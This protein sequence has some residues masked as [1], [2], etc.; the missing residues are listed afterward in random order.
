[1]TIKFTRNTV[2]LASAGTG[3]TRALVEVF[4]SLIEEGHDPVRI[5]AVTF[6]EKAAAE[7]R[8]RIRRAIFNRIP[9]LDPSEQARWMRTVAVL[10]AA[11][12]QTIHGFCGSI[13]RE[14][15]VAKGIDPG[16]SILD[17][18]S[19]IELCRAAAFETIRED[20]VGGDEGVRRL[21]GDLGLDRLIEAIPAAIYW[22]HSLGVDDNWLEKRCGEQET[23]ARKIEDE[24]SVQM[25]QYGGSPEAIG[26][27]ADAIKSGTGARRHPLK[28]RKDPS[29]LLPRVGQ[30][31]GVADARAFS[32]LVERSR[33]RFDEQKRS[34]NV[35]DFDDLLLETR[36]LLRDSERVRAACLDRFDAILVDEFQDTDDVQSQIIS[37]LGE[38]PDHPGRLG[39][40]RLLVV[41][42]PKQSI[43]R[44][45]RARV[46]EFFRMTDRVVGAEGE[47]QHLSKNFRSAAPLIAFSNAVSRGMLD[48]AGKKGVTPG[49]VDLSYR[50]T[51]S[52][53]D[54][55]SA[56]ADVAFGGITFLAARD[57]AT[58]SEG[59]G[60]EAGAIARLLL[61]RKSSNLISCWREVGMLFRS[62]THMDVYVRALEERG[63]PV[64]VVQGTG[65]YDT[66]EV[67]D[68]IAALE[69][70]VRPH[71]RMARA[72]LRMSALIGD[73]FE[74]LLSDAD[75]DPLP[76]VFGPWIERRDRATAAEILSDVV[77][78]TDFDVVMMAQRNGR[79]RVANIGKLIEITRDLARQGT[80]SL[81]DVVRYL[82]NRVHDPSIRE[83]EVQILGH[84]DDVVQC[85]TVHQAKGL[86][87]DT[88][89]LPNLAGGV[90]SG[91][92]DRIFR[93]ERWG[94]LMAP[95][96]GVHRKALPHS[97]ILEAKAYESDQEYEEEKRLLYVAMTRARKSLVLG[98]G[99]SSR[100]G[101]WSGWI[102]P[103]VKTM[104]PGGIE[105]ARA[106][107]NVGADPASEI[108]IDIVAVVD[109]RPAGPGG[110]S[111]S[112]VADVIRAEVESGSEEELPV[113]TPAMPSS[114]E[115]TPSQLS[116]LSGCRRLFYWKEIE[117]T[118]EP[119]RDSN[120]LELEL[121]SLAHRILETLVPPDA[122]ELEQSGLQALAGFFDSPEW[123]D[124]V[125]TDPECELPFVIHQEVD[126]VDCFVRG[127]I[128]ALVPSKRPRVIDYKFSRWKPG[129]DDPYQIQMTCY[130]LAAMKSLDVRSSTGELWF[131]KEPRRIRG[132]E[133]D[134]DAAETL[135][136]AL[137]RQYQSCLSEDQWPRAS[138]SYCD[139]I[140]CGFRSDCWGRDVTPSDPQDAPP[141]PVSERE[142]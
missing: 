66:A 3:K 36:N 139:R 88:V 47:V 59:R 12:I 104:V 22:L 48:G 141:A 43:Y 111:N 15:G 69:Y 72:I 113:A 4:L 124:L 99:F 82:R 98:E 70:V 78:K 49:N 134:R 94:L 75:A 57:D 20:L 135:L 7:M 132:R 96:Y 84:E 44:F 63:I 117:H 65:F 38:D 16:F 54:E 102:T 97:L 67:S 60:E 112:S 50:V 119:G 92:G 42:D 89:V 118:P 8:D 90:R 14:H 73:S 32:G 76:E 80:T 58:A 85:L 40:R 126:G 79:Q 25:E 127:R 101:L 56:G 77:R 128:D 29:A 109:G 41:G 35:M 81:D 136:E 53:E 30:I 24:L 115:L 108:P 105:R 120:R 138:E 68:L 6:T 26:R 13:L 129:S 93:S 91:Q 37:C 18:Y 5:V 95:A 11:P 46:T 110:L 122:G 45:R 121:G 52:T 86:E 74:H 27:Q 23:I 34:S 133:Y 123:M 55:L 28:N 71:D 62:M 116:V 33:R 100:P 1:M 114:L 107:E 17:E 106:G 2:V 19:R 137:F 142:V 87:F 130:A 125:E 83:P 9:K 61:E 39:S 51:L 10:P 131:L 103:V 21:F 31:A 140:S 64:Y